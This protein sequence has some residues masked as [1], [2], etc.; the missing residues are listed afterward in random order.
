MSPGYKS[1]ICIKKKK[2]KNFIG[3]NGKNSKHFFAYNC[4][5]KKNIVYKKKGGGIDL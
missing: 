4:F 5:P 3:S 2:K 1:I